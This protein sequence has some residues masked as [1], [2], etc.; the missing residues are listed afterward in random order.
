[1]NEKVRNVLFDNFED[2]TKNV[3]NLKIEIFVVVDEFYDKKIVEIVVEIDEK[4]VVDVLSF[5]LLKRNFIRFNYLLFEM[6]LTNMFVKLILRIEC[7]FALLAN[8]ISTDDFLN[9]LQKSCQ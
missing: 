1:M 7:F 4:I 2:M 6:M 3:T 9:M 5:F 8:R